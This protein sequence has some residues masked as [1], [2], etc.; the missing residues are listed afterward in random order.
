[1]LLHSKVGEM[2]GPWRTQLV[3]HCE[4]LPAGPQE[5]VDSMIAS[6]AGTASAAFGQLV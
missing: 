2:G 5:G 1:M 6:A 4:A 3:P